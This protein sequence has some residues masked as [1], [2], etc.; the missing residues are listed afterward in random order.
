MSS[1]PLSLPEDRIYIAIC[2]FYRVNNQDASGEGD[3]IKVTKNSSETYLITCKFKG[4]L[5]YGMQYLTFGCFNEGMAGLT[6]HD[7]NV[8]AFMAALS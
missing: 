2:D 8:N 4:K 6:L 7:K 5:W 1:E 3:H